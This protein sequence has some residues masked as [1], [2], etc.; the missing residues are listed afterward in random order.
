MSEETQDHN[1]GTWSGL[2]KTIIGVITTAVTAGGVWVS[3]LLGGGD[4][5]AAPAPA[6]APVINITNSNQQAQQ[7]AGGGGKTV[8]IK[9]KE[10]VKE[11]A[12]PVKKKE[13]DEFKEEAPKW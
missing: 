6:P 9:E 5:E 11:P 2:K 7:A 3:T 1:D 8:I 12:K 10:T 4:K 13:G